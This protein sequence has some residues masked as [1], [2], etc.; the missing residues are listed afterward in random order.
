MRGLIPGVLAV[1]AVCA[2]AYAADA[3][4][5][6]H[7][8]TITVTFSL[9]GD[10]GTLGVQRLIYVSNK[11]RIFVRSSRSTGN[12]GETKDVP[13][14][15]YRYESGRIVGFFTMAQHANQLTVRFDAAFQSCE[16][17]LVFGKATGGAYKLTAPNGVTNVQARPPSVSGI[18]CSIR[19][20]NPLG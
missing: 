8:K 4:P 17:S 1:V 10:A 7:N 18:S 9:T 14:G 5:Q 19:D 20:G 3:P 12:A 6:L 13:L 15:T 2:P 16:A 11:G